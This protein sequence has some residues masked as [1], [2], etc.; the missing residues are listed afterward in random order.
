[1][2]QVYNILNSRTQSIWYY[3]I[4]VNQQ[5]GKYVYLFNDDRQK[6]RRYYWASV[7]IG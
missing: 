5:I 2:R 1:L 4:R 7:G 3:F 6:R